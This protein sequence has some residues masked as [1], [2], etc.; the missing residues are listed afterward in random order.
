MAESPAE[1]AKRLSGPVKMAPSY[2]AGS[3][4]GR[5]ITP[6]LHSRRVV[7]RKPVDPRMNPVQFGQ[8]MAKK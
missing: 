6:R 1:F 8:D 4:G 7:M 2:V 5:K 3:V